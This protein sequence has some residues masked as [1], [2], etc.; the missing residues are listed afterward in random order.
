MSFTLTGHPDWQPTY[1][2]PIPVLVGAETGLAPGTWGPYTIPVS[3]GGSYMLSLSAV[4]ADEI[5]FTDVTVQHLDVNGAVVYTDFFGAIMVG[6]GTTQETNLTGPTLIRGNIWGPTLKISGQ[7]AAS[8]FLNSVLSSSGF[9]ATDISFNIYV[10]PLG[11]SDPEPKVSCG[12]ATLLGGLIT[13]PGGLLAS[14]NSA[15]LTEGTNSAAAALIPYA[16]PASITFSFGGGVT[17]ANCEIAINQFRVVDGTGIE[18]R[19][20]W[21]P[22]ALTVGYTFDFNVPACLNVLTVSNLSASATLNYNLEICAD[23]T[24]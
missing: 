18:A 9:V 1:N 14:Y 7:V 4:T 17:P 3:S 12:N 10:F 22:A 8:A 6:G 15:T 11:L 21:F 24:A 20:A 23:R 13:A 16:G 5:G 19:L 2:V